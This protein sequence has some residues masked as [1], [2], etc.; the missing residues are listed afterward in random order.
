MEKNKFIDEIVME[1]N[2]NFDCM[3]ILPGSIEK[4]SWLQ[5][6][7]SFELM[8][9]DLFEMVPTNK[10]NF[11]EVLAT[12]LDVDK[13]KI[14]DMNVK[15]SIVAEE[16]SYV[17]QLMYI[18]MEKNAEY[19]IKENLNEMASLINTNGDKIYSNAILFKNY[20]P[21]LSDSMSL[22]SI[23]KK[24]VGDF[25]HN[26]V[27]TRIVSWD[28]SWDEKVVM[29]DLNIFAHDFFDDNNII[30]IEFPFLMHNINIWYT[31]F[32]YGRDVCGKLLNKKIDKCIWFTMKSDE[33]RGSINYDEVKKII[34][35]SEKLDN[36]ITP[37][38]MT[39]EKFD[40]M[41]RKIIYNKYKVLDYMYNNYK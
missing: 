16:Y 39:E 27:Y 35:L 19:M 28:D 41:G 24:D 2:D 21:S 17:Y 7:Y 3:V 4:V 38:Y 23:T 26:R 6:T 15:T 18:D 9:L 12:K 33:I 32:S 13:Y 25:L 29:G 5:S 8:K 36:Y 31:T 37:G 20:L 22:V 14:Q 1:N 40:S 34:Y 30:K 10:D 11:M